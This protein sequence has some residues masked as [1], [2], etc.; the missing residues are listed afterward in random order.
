MGPEGM[1]I[2]SAIAATGSNAGGG[3]VVIVP[4]AWVLRTSGNASASGRSSG[5]WNCDGT[6]GALGSG[7]TP[8]AV[9]RS[10]MDAGPGRSAA[11]GVP[12]AGAAGAL[13]PSEVCLRVRTSRALLRTAGRAGAG[14]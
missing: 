2:S 14:A 11:P 9:R 6:A 1:S 5:T 12:D 10:A 3:R 7:A 4:M 8:S 13:T